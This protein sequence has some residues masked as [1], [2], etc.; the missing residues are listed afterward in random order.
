MMK[1]LGQE[2]SLDTNGI[3]MKTKKNGL[4]TPSNCQM[5]VTFTINLIVINLKEEKNH[6]INFKTF[7]IHVSIFWKE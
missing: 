4:H 6:I 3:T 2:P 7:S 1:E 5:M